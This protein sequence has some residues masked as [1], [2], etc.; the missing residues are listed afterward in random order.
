MAVQLSPVFLAERE[1]IVSVNL[2]N[3]KLRALDIHRGRKR[4]TPKS[5][6]YR[7]RKRHTRSRHTQ[8]ETRT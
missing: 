2:H 1:I 3:H 5:G 6:K 7:D 8:K 4:Y